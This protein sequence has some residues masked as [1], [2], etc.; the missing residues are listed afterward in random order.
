[1]KDSI[2]VK[3]TTQFKK[4][5]EP[6]EIKTSVNLSEVVRELRQQWAKEL[7]FDDCMCIAYALY[8]AGFVPAW[9]SDIAENIICGYGDS[10]TGF[11][12]ELLVNHTADDGYEI[13]PWPAVKDALYRCT[14][15][16]GPQ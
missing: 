15:E 5:P 12:Y 4:W 7:G 11:K 3:N 9:S 8:D 6:S 13:V 16:G 14:K 1:M 2:T 10:P